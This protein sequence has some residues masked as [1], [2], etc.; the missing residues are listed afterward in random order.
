LGLQT[1]KYLVVDGIHNVI[2]ILEEI[3]NER[4]RD[5]EFIEANSCM[6][7]C[8]GGPLTVANRFPPNHA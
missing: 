5:I 3:E 1:E 4:L 2:D 6:G 8:I 7:G